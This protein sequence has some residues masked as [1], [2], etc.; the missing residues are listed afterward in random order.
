MY[1][2]KLNNIFVINLQRSPERMEH[3]IQQSN[4]HNLPANKIIRCEAIDGLNH[5][6]T[7]KEL[8]MFS[9]AN[10]L[11]TI[12]KNVVKKMMGNQLSHYYLLQHII[13]QQYEYTIIMQD[14]VKFKNGIVSYIDKILEN[15]PENAEI[16]NIGLHK[17]ALF[18]HV[19][20]WDFNNKNDDEIICASHYN[21][22]IGLWKKDLNPCSLAYIVTLKG[23][24]NLVKHFQEY[25]FRQTTDMNYNHYLN[26]FNI[27]YGSS[28]VLATTDTTIRSDIFTS[29]HGRKL[30]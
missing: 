28:T 29:D 10:F 24:I 3:F 26:F 1:M 9:R 20:E 16:I 6:F 4:E 11:E 14:D 22:Y 8:S 15:V 5:T 23:A 2:E 12:D 18:S 30:V 13:Q 19:I 21:E 7:E 27:F 25:G 17:E